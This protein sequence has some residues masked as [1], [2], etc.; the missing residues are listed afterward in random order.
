MKTFIHRLFWFH[1][2]LAS[3]LLIPYS[4]LSQGGQG[5]FAGGAAGRTAEVREGDAASYQHILTPGDRGEWPISARAGETIIVFVSSTT[6][7]PAAQIVDAAGKVLAENDDIRPG[8]QDSL[9]L[10]RFPAAGEYKILVKGFKSAAG[11]RYTLTLRR[12]ISTDLHKAERNVAVLGRTRAH[13]HRF[14]ADAGETL[15]VTTRSAVFDPEIEIYAPN[16]ER[17]DAPTRGLSGGRAVSSVFRATQKGDYYL[18]VASGR[19]VTG[20]Y[21]V[22]V[23][24]ARVAPLTI[25]AANPTRR[26]ESGGL[27]LWRFTATAGEVIRIDASAPGAGTSVALRHLPPAAKAESQVEAA[28]AEDALAVLP[29]SPKAAGEMVALVKRTGDYQVEVSQPLGL[30]VEYTLATYRAA[31]PWTAGSDPS[32]KLTIGGSDYW[33]IEGKAGQIVKMEGTADPFDIAL[34]LFNPQGERVDSNDDGAGGRNSLITALLKESGK[35]LV[36]VHSFGDGGGGSYRLQRKPDPVHAIKVGAR[37]EG[38]I[39][40]GGSDIWSFEGKSGQTVILSVRSKDFDPHVVVFGP[41]AIEVANDENGRE[42][43]D[44][45]I[46][47]RLPLKGAYTIWVSSGISGGKYVVRVVDGD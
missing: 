1:L 22:T 47:V 15:V 8:V 26:M 40:T 46:S 32:G 9:L 10:Y 23:A 4:A 6:F 5:G 28:G 19:D 14:A 41:D 11:G 45:L 13:W 42:G 12:F 16:G 37:T 36:R 21:A 30:E 38:S 27:D 35:Y 33:V 44:S 25:G 18:R 43:T 7:D 39:G 24:T 31:K 3:L 17:M 2:I 20:G 29:S 34:D